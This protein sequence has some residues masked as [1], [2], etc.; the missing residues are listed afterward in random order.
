M[1]INEETEYIIDN[2]K[3]FHFDNLQNIRILSIINCDLT[4]LP[5]EI[6]ILQN[7]IILNLSN[8]KLTNIELSNP[9]LVVL[10][11]AYNKLITFP[12]FTSQIQCLNIINN[13][14]ANIPYK[15]IEDMRLVVFLYDDNPFLNKISDKKNLLI[16]ESRRQKF[17]VDL[18]YHQ[19]IV[20]FF[21]LEMKPI[22]ENY[23][24][25]QISYSALK[26]LEESIYED[27]FM[28]EFYQK[29]KHNYLKL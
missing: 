25:K 10:D 3:T 17:L 22:L 12:K 26:C 27:Y 1:I 4:Q 18:Y 28:Y 9:K 16:L 15:K 19:D 13:N 5:L 20:N 23:E 2:Q 7:L 14:I 24:N 8:N 29:I 21:H 6:S 11:C